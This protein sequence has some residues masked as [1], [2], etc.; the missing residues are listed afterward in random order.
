MELKGELFGQ[1]L[2]R[3]GVITQEQLDEALHRQQTT[4]PDRKVGEILIRLG[5][6]GKR[7]FTEGLA[8]Q[9]GV[10]AFGCRNWRFL[11]RSRR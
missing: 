8:D 4:M 7:Q 11:H 5:H 3:R 10:A 1:C 2:M 6:I 9:L